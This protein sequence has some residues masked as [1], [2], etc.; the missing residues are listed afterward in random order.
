MTN[1]GL[2]LGFLKSR[3][4]ANVDY[5]IRKTSGML[6]NITVAPSLGFSGNSYKENLGEIENRGI[7]VNLNAV[8]LRKTEQELE[9]AVSFMGSHNQSKLLEISKE[10]KGINAQNNRNESTPGNVYEEG[11]SLSAL[12]AVRSLGIDPATGKELF[13]TK[14]GKVTTTWDPA[15][16]VICGNTEPKFFGNISTNLYWRGFNL[17]AIFSYR[18]HADLYNQTLVDRVE[19]AD[20][21]YNA[22]TR[23]LDKRWQKTGD[24]TFY[25]D[26]AD[27]MP[28][29]VSSR[30]V[31]QEN[32]LALKSLSL[33]YD[34]K[35][36]FLKR[37]GLE[38]LRLSFYMNDLFRASTIK[39]ERGLTYPFARSFV[40][41]L[42]VGF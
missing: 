22:D 35:R 26:I 29:K 1:V 39:E 7:E 15:D 23:V 25:K 30:F 34:V 17:N 41:G 16:K 21:N 11:E 6:T 19:G 31:Q 20:P 8:I 4:R 38:T 13:L 40:F 36:E 9:W 14:E 3:I 32:T 12:K 42:N 24:H 37:Y 2:E 33:S 18:I 5:Y 10:L 27:K 28:S